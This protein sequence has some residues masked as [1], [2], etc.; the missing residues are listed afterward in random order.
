MFLK[1]LGYEILC[2]NIFDKYFEKNAWNKKY[3]ITIANEIVGIMRNSKID[4]TMID[5]VNTINNNSF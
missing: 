4:E 5:I 3:I 1:L 2:D